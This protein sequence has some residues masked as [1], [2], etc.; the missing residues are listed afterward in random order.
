M[1]SENGTELL[2]SW[3][4]SVEYAVLDWASVLVPPPVIVMGTLGNPLAA[5]VLLRLPPRLS[6]LSAARYAVALLVVSTVRLFAE[7][8]LEWFAYVT[9]TPYIM[10]RADWICRL[11]KFLLLPTCTSSSTLCRSHYIYI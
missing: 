8:A 3:M 4:S 10:H 6:D 2:E 7:G 1:S 5:G 9:S 11:W